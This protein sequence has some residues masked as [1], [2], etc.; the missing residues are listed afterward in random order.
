MDLYRLS[1]WQT[2]ENQAALLLLWAI[3]NEIYQNF[4]ELLR[5]ELGCNAQR[6]VQGVKRWKTESR[7]QFK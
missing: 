1:N 7:N 6:L 3:H 5:N 4:Y 2:R